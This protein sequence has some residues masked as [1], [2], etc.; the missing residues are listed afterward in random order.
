ME[1]HDPKFSDPRVVAVIGGVLAALAGL[2]F[3]WAWRQGAY[4]GD[5]FYPGA[6]GVFLLLAVLALA[7]PFEGRVRGA[8]LVAL[9]AL[10]AIAGWMALSLLWT[11]TRGATISYAE[12]AFLYV[13]LFLIGLWLCVTLA[14]NPTLA[15]LPVAVGA[16]A[17]SIAVVLTLANGHD[18][19]TYFHGEA[20]LRLPLGYR[21]ANAAFFLICLWPTL[22]LAMDRARHPALR[23]V[24]VGGATALVELALLCQSRG[25]VPAA[26]VATVAWIAFSS[27]RLRAA[28][29]LVLIAIPTAVA[30]PTLLKVFQH[31]ELKGLG[32]YMHQAAG[33]V[34]LTTLLALVLGAVMVLVLERRTEPSPEF[35]RRLGL[36]LGSAAALV[37]VVGLVAFLVHE[38]GPTKFVDQRVEQFNAGGITNFSGKEA[39]FGVNIGSNRNDFW[40]VSL[41]QAKRTP[42]LGGG[43]GS[44]QVTYLK[45]RNSPET[46]RDPHSVEMLMLGE[47]GVPGL[48]LFV[49]FVVATLWAA[50]RS[51]RAGPGA[52][53]TVAGAAT[54]VVYWTMHASYDWLWNYPVVTGT[55]AFLAGIAV[56]GGV[57]MAAREGGGNEPATVT[58][59]AGGGGEGAT[60][61]GLGSDLL[62]RRTRFGVAAAALFLALVAAPLFL[63]ERY[64]G[65]AYGEEAADPTAAYRDFRYAANLDPFDT[66][67]LNAKGLLAAQQGEGARAVDAFEQAVEREPEGYAQRLY[68]AE[69]LYP[70]ELAAARRQIAIAAELNPHEAVV[71]AARKKIDAAASGGSKKSAGSGA[72]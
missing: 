53:L 10:A 50:V 61:R 15:L 40:R 69:L 3:W 28:A 9:G 14:R 27:S 30:A 33:M 7:G 12:H 42:V 20:T 31:G 6:I 41:D 63:A 70:E 38:G 64:L 46:P 54:G 59:T 71:I 13:A 68:L 39:R 34:A 1:A 65:R 16:I 56:A 45:H 52:A 25:S 22:A 55:M 24:M 47:L 32:P 18:L 49:V 44:F 17:T 57:R 72:P 58:A 62:G 5:V 23:V 60:G 2:I 4:F 21:N 26:L 11:P 48:L 35:Q 37:A 67:A 51:R 19:N 29:Y 66:V 8:A 43:A 36:G